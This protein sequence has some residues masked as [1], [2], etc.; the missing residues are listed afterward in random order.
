M[1]ILFINY[2][3]PPIGAGGGNANAH[4]A[5]Q[6]V[7]MGHEVSV[8]T[9][10]FKNLPQDEIQDG[11]R[12]IRIPAWRRHADKCSILE[13]LIFMLSSLLFGWI[14]HKRLRPDV[15]VA[16]FSIPC[17]AAALLMR[18]C[19]GTPYLVALRGGDVPGFMP[20][21][22]SFYHALTA[23]LTR[24][25]WSH[26][27]ALTANSSGLAAL[28]K[29]FYSHPR[30][31]V[32]P[33]GVEEKFFFARMTGEVP[34]CLKILAVGRLSAQKHVERLIA[35]MARLK[36]LG[37][38]D[39]EL[40][41]VGDGPLRSELEEQ[42]RSSGL[43]DHQVKFLGWK[44][45]E[46]LVHC[47]READVFSLASDFEGMPN[48]I[49]EAMASGLAIVATD[50]AGTVE[51]VRQGDN[52]FLLDRN[53]LELFEQFFMDLRAKPDT[54]LRMQR[55]S[56]E[57]ARDYTWQKVAAAYGRLCEQSRE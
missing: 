30:L 49:L 12:L 17:G 2:E 14:W 51:L 42:A 5:R 28:A 55:R 26:A 35:A 9:S 52:G 16:F 10:R 53:H 7:Q 43:L 39:F 29:D 8:L 46:E 15:V 4:I 41:L 34:R 54:L 45:G 18:C 25:I 40:I 11:L 50:A 47:Y 22:L 48:V 33:N 20:E 57:L 6:L 32:I 21:Q 23:W 56:L 19:F 36:N 31:L 27:F 38:D 44:A 37:R 24:L 1:K 13:M 3:F